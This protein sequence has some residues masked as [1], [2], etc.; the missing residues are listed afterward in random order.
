MTKLEKAA[1][2]F[3]EE[4][5]T[6]Q[7]SWTLGFEAGA[8]WALEQMTSDRSRV[9]AVVALSKLQGVVRPVHVGEALAAV[10]KEIES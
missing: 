9:V 4:K 10:R 8:R 7:V 5:S 1:I 3:G 6:F 2:S